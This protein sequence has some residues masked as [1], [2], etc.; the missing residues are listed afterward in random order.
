[1][2]HD[3]SD[4]NGLSSG[5]NSTRSSWRTFDEP[6][7]TDAPCREIVQHI[8]A[9]VVPLLRWCF[10]RMP[11]RKELRAWCQA[12]GYGHRWNRIAAELRRLRV[13]DAPGERAVERDDGVWI[14]VDMFDELGDMAPLCPFVLRGVWL[15]SFS[16]SRRE[17]PCGSWVCPTCGPERVHALANLLKERIGHLETVYV[18]SAQ[19]TPGLMGRMG[20]RRKANQEWLWYRR[21]DDA[22]FFV[23]DA[24]IKGSRDPKSCQAMLPAEALALFAREV[25]WVP[26]HAQHGWTTLWKPPEPT[27]DHG[28][29]PTDFLALNRLS[30][31]QAAE[32][33]SS[34][35]VEA[36]KRFGVAIETGAI[37][38]AVH[39]RLVALLHELLKALRL[40][41][42][43]EYAGRQ[44][45]RFDDF[46]QAVSPSEFAEPQ[47]TG[48]PP[49]VG[50]TDIDVIDEFDDFLDDVTPDQFS[51]PPEDD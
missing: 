23:S 33:M 22:V 14:A 10:E 38:D 31:A 12:N 45:D 21:M 27:R 13:V 28:D 7:T 48:H 2:S 16:L 18:A 30:D 25:G 35:K 40:E 1:M 5:S 37:P 19:W 20:K 17:K 24:P 15:D 46:V 3:P 34:F 42:D 36:H 26:G 8:D 47:T 41:I 44:L 4:H 49:S 39:P 43:A 9:D 6:P 11:T 50:T 51:D 32:L 29:G